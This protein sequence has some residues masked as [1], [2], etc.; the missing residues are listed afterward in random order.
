M[1]VPH[2]EVVIVGGGIHGAG[3]AQAAAAAG[4]RVLLLEKEQPAA[5]TSSRSSKLIHGGLRYL[6]SGQL[7][8]VWEALHEREILLRI[9]PDLVRLMPFL[10][11][12]YA[13]S[14][15]RPWQIQAGLSLYA[16]FLGLKPHG[17]FSRLDKA[18]W[19]GLAGLRTEGLRAVFS[20][21]DAQTDDADLTRAVLTSAAA[22]GAEVLFPAS[23]ISAARTKDGCWIDYLF[24]G[25]EQSCP[26][27]VLVNASGPWVNL[28]QNQISPAP[29]KLAV[30]LVQGTHIHLDA[31]ISASVFYGESPHDQRPVFIMPWRQGT[32]VGTTE[33][34]FTG[35]PDRVEPLPWEIAYLEE[36]LR[37]YFPHYKGRVIGSMA[38]LRVL[39][40][41]QGR[42]LHRSRETILLSDEASRPH[43]IAIYG[44]KLTT[45]RAT[46][47]RVMRLARKTLPKRK[48]IASTAKLPL[49]VPSPLAGEG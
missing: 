2:Y 46:A 37:F 17:R 6:E 43:L 33:T 3:V 7:R 10:I 39:P 49:Q 1:T 25:Q 22:L 15:H 12:V 31:P 48:P 47:A 30:D 36:A 42:P 9:A 19:E 4:Y 26:A 32:L 8:L 34:I 27:S 38:G 14:L 28:V 45:Y 13:Q 24:K 29:P 40:A 16:L 18:H 5:G 35:D 20:Y 44:G 23:F 11:P 21:L 41:G